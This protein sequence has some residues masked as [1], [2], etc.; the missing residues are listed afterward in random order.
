MMRVALSCC[1]VG[2]IAACGDG[3][4]RDEGTEASNEGTTNPEPAQEP[5]ASACQPEKLSDAARPSW[6]TLNG[7]HVFWLEGGTRTAGAA[8]VL[9]RVE[10]RGGTPEVIASGLL[11]GWAGIAEDGA[12]LYLGGTDAQ[13]HRI[14]PDGS[15]NVALAETGGETASDLQIA[16]PYLY[17]RSAIA[18][19]TQ[20]NYAA[21]VRRVRTDA[22]SP[23]EVLWSTGGESYTSSLAV[24]GDYFFTAVFN[25]PPGVDT[26]RADGQILRFSGAGDLGVP[27]VT[28][29]LIPQI[30]AADARYVYFSAQTAERRA[31][32]W[33]V[34]ISG[35]AAELLGAAAALNLVRVEGQVVIRGD[36]IWWGANQGRVLRATAG[37]ETSTVVELAA[38]RMLG[39]ATDDTDL[40]FTSSSISASTGPA[41]VWR[42]PLGCTLD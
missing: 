35:G 4:A 30:H 3:G 25:W 9:N 22:S 8:G 38:H 37:G 41:G 28:D 42:V 29:L 36:T 21:Q 32:L 5:E 17:W 10:R 15:E 14:A 31:E 33:R 13:I 20:A 1:C 40:Y 7:E 39:L 26:I 6:I 11:A 2:W 16:P 23:P 27:L 19:P 18:G 24:S 12:Y 34:P